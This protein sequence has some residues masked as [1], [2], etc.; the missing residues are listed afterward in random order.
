MHKTTISNI[1]LSVPTVIHNTNF[2]EAFE[3]HYVVD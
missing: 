2:T 1:P 3:V